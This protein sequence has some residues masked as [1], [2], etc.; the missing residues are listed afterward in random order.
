VAVTGEVAIAHVIG[1]QHNEVRRPGGALLQGI[2]LRRAGELKQL[3]SRRHTVA[4]YRSAKLA[5][6]KQLRALTEEQLQRAAERLRNPRPGSRIEAAKEYGI[7]VTLL[8]EQLRR[9]PEQRVATMHA[10]AEVMESV[11]GAARRK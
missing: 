10:L 1:K 9:T 3:T 11:R 2:G 5:L 6:V 4:A 8:M 7:D